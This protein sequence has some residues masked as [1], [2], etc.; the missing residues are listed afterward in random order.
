[1]ARNIG[2]RVDVDKWNRETR[3]CKDDTVHGI[4]KVPASVIN[5]EIQ[6]FETVA[7][8]IFAHFEQSDKSPSVAE[9]RTEYDRRLYDDKPEKETLFDVYANF[10]RK[11][12]ALN[13]WSQE[14][15]RRHENV[16][17]HLQNYNPGLT[18]NDL[19]ED[20]LFS[21]MGYM[22][23]RHGDAEQDMR[24][25]TVAKNVEQIREFLRWAKKNGYYE[26][27]LHETFHPKLKGTD[28][29]VPSIIYLSW[30]ELMRLYAFK[31]Q[32]T[33]LN[34]VKDVFCFMCFTSLRY[35]DVARLTHANV[36]EDSIRVIMKGA[37]NDLKIDLNEY[38]RA[39]LEKYRKV[40][41]PY[42]NALPVFASGMIDKYLKTIGEAVGF[43]QSVRVVYSV[44]TKRYEEVKPKYELLTADCARRTFVVNSR[45]LGI[46]AQTVISWTGYDEYETMRPYIQAV[47]E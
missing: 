30:D 16:K 13:S 27:R 37:V 43:Y 23:S 10:I 18:F 32:R 4:N 1:V 33:H 29:N 22:Q 45:I 42:N 11:T 20:T 14:T 17:I 12:G 15:V 39:I 46:P 24:S 8:E 47:E 3:R 28:G 7:E 35:S 25:T 38:S 26:G 6:R 34:R 2:Y 5:R 9:F 44:D 21:F 31:F 41:L 40:K 19:S 36:S